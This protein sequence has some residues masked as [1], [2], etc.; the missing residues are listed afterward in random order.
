MK[1]VVETVNDEIFYAVSSLNAGK[2][3]NVTALSNSWSTGTHTTDQFTW[4]EYNFF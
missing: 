1:G 4:V 3:S 2:W